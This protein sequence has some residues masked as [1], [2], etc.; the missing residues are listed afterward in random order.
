MIPHQPA[1][2][3][4]VARPHLTPVTNRKPEPYEFLPLP[5]YFW[6]SRPDT[7]PLG[8]E[9]VATALYLAKGDLKAAAA[10]LKVTVPRL[11]RLIRKDLRLKRLIEIARTVT[12]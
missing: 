1:R 2:Q 7:V 6:D 10:R 9:E 5:C 12:C 8:H 3:N 4:L 11:M